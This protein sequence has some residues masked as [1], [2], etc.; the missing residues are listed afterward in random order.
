MSVPTDCP[1]RNE[2][3]GWTGDIQVFAPTANFLYDTSGMLQS[4]LTD[5]ANEQEK[6]GTGAIG[7]FIPSCFRFMPHKPMAVWGDAAVTVPWDLYQASGDLEILQNQF[8]SM[9]NWIEEGIPK[10]ESDGLLWSTST[11]EQLGDW[12]D[13]SAPPAEPGNG[14]TNS[15]LVADAYLVMVTDRMVKIC[16]AL[17]RNEDEQHYRD[18][19]SRRRAA[20]ADKYITARGGVVSDSQTATALVLA[21]S[22][23]PTSEIETVFA[24]RLEHLIRAQL[25]F[26]IG[27]G[28]VGTSLLGPALSS[29]GRDQVFYRMLLCTK[30][31]SWLYPVKMGA[32][33][34]W[35]RW[36][37]M[38]EDGSI[39][40]GEMTSF[41]HY[42]L[43]SVGGWMHSYMVGMTPSEPGWKKMRV[44]PRPGGGLKFAEGSHL[45]PYGLARV[46]WEIS[47]ESQIKVTV[48][49][50]PNT[51][52]EV[53]LPCEQPNEGREVGSGKHEFTRAYVSVEWPCK[54][55]YPRGL[56]TPPEDDW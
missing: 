44:Q 17:G 25:H 46:R 3:L 13:P 45:T 33:T 41:N 53:I 26:R 12:L 20:F 11:E 23:A 48:V 52:A 16:A 4:W 28:F 27:T 35:E 2:R 56:P 54:P 49:V 34:M 9:R 36:D 10:E 19:A 5:V 32:T 29:A 31:P 50:P 55:I 8:Q 18:L 15:V 47:I 43:G 42:A 24:A 37:S 1:Q 6:T 14:R 38:L 21:F 39:N 30:N 40:P 7:L 22:L 51:T